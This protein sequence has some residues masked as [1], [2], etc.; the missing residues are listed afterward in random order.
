MGRRHIANYVYM[1]NVS[2]CQNCDVTVMTA[3]FEV[4]N[5]HIFL[6]CVPKCDKNY[7]RYD[8]LIVKNASAKS[9]LPPPPLERNPKILAV[10]L[11]QQIPAILRT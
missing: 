2:K 4:F 10:I 11:F 8:I 3:C 9:E 5:M 1:K 7:M 6:Q